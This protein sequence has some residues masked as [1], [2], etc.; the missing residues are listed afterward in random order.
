[1]EHRVAGL[2]STKYLCARRAGL[3][4]WADG[5]RGWHDAV[6]PGGEGQRLARGTKGEI[7]RGGK[8][9]Q[10]ANR[11]KGSI[12][13]GRGEKGGVSDGEYGRPGDRSRGCGGERAETDGISNER[14]R[15]EFR[16]GKEDNVRRELRV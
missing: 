7:C 8:L 5:H 13:A 3:E 4:S 6:G 16:V 11:G 2:G 15:G 12:R 9:T 10:V 1:M 14:V